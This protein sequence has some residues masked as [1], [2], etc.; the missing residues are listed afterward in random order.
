M[1][2][3]FTVQQGLIDTQVQCASM[4]AMYRNALKSKIG[5]GKNDSDSTDSKETAIKGDLKQWKVLISKQVISNHFSRV[6]SGVGGL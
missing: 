3:M 2:F 1:S 5:K 6:G 4:I